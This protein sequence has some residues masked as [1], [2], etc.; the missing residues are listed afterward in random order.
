MFFFDRCQSKYAWALSAGLRLH[1]FEVPDPANRLVHRVELPDLPQTVLPP[2]PA[3]CRPA[4]PPF[5][6]VTEGCGAIPV[7][8]AGRAAATGR[9]RRGAVRCDAARP[10][11]EVAGRGRVHGGGKPCRYGLGAAAGGQRGNGQACGQG[12]VLVQCSLHSRDTQGNYVSQTRRSS[13]RA[14]ARHAAG[15]SRAVRRTIM[16]RHAAG[17]CR[18]RDKKGDLRGYRKARSLQ[19]S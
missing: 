3:S 8:G 13:G 4:F 10:A 7:R 12:E 11:E 5:R 16:V 15:A 18:P 17:A 19:G 14:R 2:G 1:K 6:P 9:R